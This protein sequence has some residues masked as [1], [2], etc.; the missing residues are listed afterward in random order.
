MHVDTTIKTMNT[1]HSDHCALAATIPLIGDN[2]THHSPTTTQI[3]TT[4]THPPFIL[5][6]PKPLIELYQL[7]DTSTNKAQ[8]AATTYLAQLTN[9]PTITT[10]KIDKA[11]DHIITMLNTYHELAQKT[12]PMAQAISHPEQEKI[13]PPPQSLR[14]QTA[15][16]PHET[17]Q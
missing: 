16:T 5:P 15:K 7:G 1:N 3:P 10:N 9:T 11:A 2:P 13:H 4:I 12:W 6:I 8:L 14:Q 17:P